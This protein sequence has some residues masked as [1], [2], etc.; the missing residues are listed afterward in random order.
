MLRKIATIFVVILL[1]PVFVSAQEYTVLKPGGEIIKK[2]GDL[3]TVEAQRVKTRISG[4]LD[5]QNINSSFSNVLLSPDGTI[6]TLKYS[7]PW[8][9]NFGYN[10]QDWMLQWFVAPAD[11]IL[12][13]AG[14]ATFENADAMSVELKIVRVTWDEADLKTAGTVH[15][16]WYEAIGNGF[17]DITAFL[18]NPDWT[19]AWSSQDGGLPEPFG[20]DIWSDGGVGFTIEPVAAGA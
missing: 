15:H 3:K 16:G 19:G 18:D 7:P 8:D 2:Y 17:N 12:M 5:K 4:N 1:L 14:F 11:L 13:F 6:D 10:G 9:T 20:N